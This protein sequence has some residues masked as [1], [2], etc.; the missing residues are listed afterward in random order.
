MLR[1]FIFFITDVANIII[2]S[3]FPQD[4]G[5]YKC[6]YSFYDLYVISRTFNRE[7]LY[8]I[9]FLSHRCLCRVRLKHT[10]REGL[11]NTL[12]DEVWWRAMRDRAAT[13]SL[14]YC[15]TYRRCLSWGRHPPSA[16]RL[17]RG[18]TS[19]ARLLATTR[20]ST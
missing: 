2:I 12:N 14:G 11:G 17:S 13:N 9:I 10:G 8:R 3:R 18:V 7:Y 20:V 4:I 15:T 19:C 16:L 5:K 6:A 1:I